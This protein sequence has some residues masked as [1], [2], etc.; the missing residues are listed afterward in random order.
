MMVWRRVSVKPNLLPGRAHGRYQAHS[1]EHPQSPVDG[2]QRY[3]GNSIAHLPEDSL[4]IGM[5]PR[6]GHFLEDDYAL[7]RQLQAFTLAHFPEVCKALLGFVL[8]HLRTPPKRNDYYLRVY[9][10]AGRMSRLR[11][12]V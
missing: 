4:R 6:P 1:V 9:I 8:T 12:P 2:I 3:G 10:K 5:I 11:A 7:V